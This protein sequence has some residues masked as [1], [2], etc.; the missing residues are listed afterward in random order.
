MIVCPGEDLAPW[1]RSLKG[2]DPAL[3]IRVW[4]DVADVTE[5]EFALVWNHPPGELRRYP[6]LK[7]IASLGAGVD[8]IL[9]DSELPRGVPVTKVVDA[10]LMRAMTEYV[11]LAVLNHYRDMDRYRRDQERQQWAPRF[12]RPREAMAIGIMGLGQLGADSAA[13]L[14]DMGFAVGGWSRT[15]KQIDGVESFHGS[16]QLTRFLSRTDVLICL[17]P[18]TPQTRGILNRGTFQG[19]RRGSYVINVARGGH[20]VEEDLVEALDTGQLSGACLDVFREEPLPARHPFWVHPRIL[21]TPHVSSLTDPDA[22]AP[23]ILENYR[24]VMAGD[25]PLYQVDVERGY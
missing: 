18:L 6:N 16:E 9:G 17:L 21:V 15:P 19:L 10:A 4:P 5:I 24:R 1:I 20:L 12:P 11:A 22:V 7:C 8:R 13:K 14:R 23:Q 25:P 3:A 2:L